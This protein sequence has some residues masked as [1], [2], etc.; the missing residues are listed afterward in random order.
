YAS[1]ARPW[2]AIAMYSV[3]MNAGKLCF[4]AWSQMKLLQNMDPEKAEAY[5][6]IGD[7]IAKLMLVC[8]A[9]VLLF[10]LTGFL[11]WK[12]NTYF[13]IADSVLMYTTYQVIKHYF[14]SGKGRGNK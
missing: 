14:P 6:I 1:G 12:P 8:A 11:L 13:A 2:S 4:T 3:Q 5:R 10:V 7:I 9:I